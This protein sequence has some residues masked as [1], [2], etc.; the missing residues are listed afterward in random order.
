MLDD[1]VNHKEAK[2]GGDVGLLHRLRMKADR[3]LIKYVGKEVTNL[4]ASNVLGVSED[5]D[6]CTVYDNLSLRTN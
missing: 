2:S 5:F 1:Y 6:S 3:N 4:D